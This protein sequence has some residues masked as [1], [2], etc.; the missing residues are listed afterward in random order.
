M[1]LNCVVFDAKQEI[2]FDLRKILLDGSNL[3]F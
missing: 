1:V 2:V 3:I